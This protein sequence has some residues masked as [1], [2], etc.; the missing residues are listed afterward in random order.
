MTFARPN[1]L[2]IT[3]P[4]NPRDETSSSIYTG[5]MHVKTPEI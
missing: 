4:G 3:I 2:T 5:P 1:G